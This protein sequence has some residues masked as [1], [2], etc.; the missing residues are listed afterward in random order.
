MTNE[1]PVRPTLLQRPYRQ[2]P[3]L[4]PPA[5]P[6]PILMFQSITALKANSKHKTGQVHC[7]IRAVMG[8]KL[9]SA[10]GGFTKVEVLQS[11]PVCT[12]IHTNP[13]YTAWEHI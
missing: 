1:L 6:S 13:R 9:G 11:P 7:R 3:R 8:V 2:A 4:H 5:R 12:I 10:D